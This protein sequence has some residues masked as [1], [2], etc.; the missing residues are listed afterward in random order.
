MNLQT[1][2]CFDQAEQVI[3]E[4]KIYFAN[5]HTVIALIE[6]KKYDEAIEYLKEMILSE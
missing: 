6:E 1:Q 4:K 2:N 5:I 3:D